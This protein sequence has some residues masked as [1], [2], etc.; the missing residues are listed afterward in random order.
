[1]SGKYTKSRTPQLAANCLFENEA[2]KPDS[3][4]IHRAASR[5]VAGAPSAPNSL[6]QA[7]I[8]ACCAKDNS[9]QDPTA[10]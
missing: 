2:N 7:G 6:T 5:R 4:L 10:S 9:A 8:D 1:L 3:L